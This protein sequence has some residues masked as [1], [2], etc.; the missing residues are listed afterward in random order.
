VIEDKIT[1]LQTDSIVV[2]DARLFR[3]PIDH[4]HVRELALSIRRRG[5]IHTILV[6]KGSLQLIVGAHRL[7]AYRLNEQLFPKEDWSKIE[8]RYA[9]EVSDEEIRALELEENVRRRSLNW[10]DE[11]TAIREFHDLQ[12]SIPGWTM[13]KTGERLG[14][15]SGTISRAVQVAVEIE[16]G[17]KALNHASSI[18]SAHN[19]IERQQGRAI[20]GEL[21]VLVGNLPIE[22]GASATIPDLPVPIEVGDFLEWSSQY[23]G[24]KF[25]HLHCDFPYGIGW[26]TARKFNSSPHTKSKTYGDDENTYIAL[27]EELIKNWSRIVSP[28]A[29]GF[30]WLSANFGIHEWTRQM[31]TKIEGLRIDPFP[32]IWHKSDNAGAIPDPERGGRRTY[33]TA[34]FMTYGDRK[35]VAPVSLS[36]SAPTERAE[37]IHI[38]QKPESVCRHFMRM[39]VDENTRL[40]DP[41]CGS[42]TALRAANSLGAGSVF[43]LERDPELAAEAQAEFARSIPIT[44]EDG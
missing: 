21:D 4:E 24:P 39:T 44:Y 26:D 18:R 20:A 7:E 27:V 28:T 30:F 8:S 34:L 9:S 33:E 19:F 10:R 1:H 32:L 35:I 3:R 41:T 25:N 2:T 17:N 43:G 40:L 16:K 37:R 14:L 23:S 36:Y 11:A 12:Q 6:E 38:S 13:E 22:G 15:S 29:H 31:F 5:L 42:G